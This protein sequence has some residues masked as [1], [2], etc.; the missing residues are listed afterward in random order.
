M[1]TKIL[2]MIAAL[3]VLS[4]C[5]NLRYTDYG[6]PTDFLKAKRDVV[7]PQG[8]VQ[9]EQGIVMTTPASTKKEQSIATTSEEVAST[10]VLV[11][12]AEENFKTVDA[13][14]KSM[15]TVSS[16]TVSAKTKTTAAVAVVKVSPV[17]SRPVVNK[18]ARKVYN[19]AFP[20]VGNGTSQTQDDVMFILALI[21]A[22]LIPPLAVYLVDGVSNRFWLNLVLFLLAI[23]IAGALVSVIGSLTWLLMLIAIVHAL[24]IVLGEI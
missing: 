7:K 11:V 24:L 5:T 13:D 21:L 1:K 4:S 23:G 17:V 14:S 9:L 6:R 18:I 3:A 19:K 22:F 10:E 8:K 16:K 12:V 15:E 20:L 2:T